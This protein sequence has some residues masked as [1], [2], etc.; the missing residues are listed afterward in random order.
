MAKNELRVGE[1]RLCHLIDGNPDTPEAVV[2][3]RN[4]GTAIEATFPLS[5]MFDAEGPRPMVVA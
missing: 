2:M 3:L 5:G 4:T 1:P